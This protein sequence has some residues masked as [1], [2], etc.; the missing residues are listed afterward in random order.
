VR[1]RRVEEENLRSGVSPKG[2]R[3]VRDRFQ[4]RQEKERIGERKLQ[5]FDK[6]LKQQ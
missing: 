1:R 3:L 2:W 6:F 5:Q 4:I